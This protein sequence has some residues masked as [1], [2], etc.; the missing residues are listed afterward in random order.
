MKKSL[1]ILITL[2]L[3][4]YQTWSQN[5]AC[6]YPTLSDSAYAGI[7]TCGPGQE[8]YETFG[9]SALRI[10]DSV[11]DIDY[12]FNY[13]TFNFNQPHFYLKFAKGRLDYYVQRVTFKHFLWEYEYYGRMVCQQRLLLEKE[14]LQK[15]F[16]SL[17]INAREEN[18][19]YAYDFFRDNCATRVRDMVENS[20][21]YRK[22][23]KNDFPAEENSYRSLIHKYTDTCLLWWQLGFDLLLG[24]P[25][26]KTLT[27]PQYMYNPLEMMVQYDTLVLSDGKAVTESPQ[28]ILPQIWKASPTRFSPTLC[29]WILF[30][31]VL[32]LSLV[33]LSTGWRLNWLDA[34]LFAI[35]V[36]VSLLLLYLW[37]ISDHTCCNNNFNLLWANPLLIWILV[38][39]RKPN[40]IVS[41]IIIAVYV[42]FFAGFAWWPQQIN[43]AVIPIA[44]TLLAR[45]LFRFFRKW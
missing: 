14:E 5:A 3:C 34:T 13:G 7:I 31:I 20:L 16:E 2:I 41:L 39:I 19:Y 8:V 28:T 36:I 26:D 30:G 33:S 22:L 45:M 11:N 4:S 44:L 43:P 23:L 42:I 37:F 29:F 18:K 35:T 27:S 15:L 17:M 21:Q 40:Y 10:C 38:R 6:D 25:C 24:S 1:I 9:H 12:V 32:A